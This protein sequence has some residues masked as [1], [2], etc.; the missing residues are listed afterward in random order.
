MDDSTPSIDITAF[1]RTGT[2]VPV[3]SLPEEYRQLI[4][5]A[6]KRAVAAGALSPSYLIPQLDGD[7]DEVR[8]QRVFENNNDAFAMLT[9]LYTSNRMKMRS[10]LI[11]MILTTTMMMARVP[12]IWSISYFVCMIRLVSTC[13]AGKPLFF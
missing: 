5:D 4:N 9:F 11:W 1:N 12:K 10:T 13:I 2:L 8:P 6:K 7:D 3:D